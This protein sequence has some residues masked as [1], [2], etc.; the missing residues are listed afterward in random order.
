MK[1]PGFPG[2][3]N[4]IAIRPDRK[5]KSLI[6]QLTS[7]HPWLRQLLDWT[8]TSGSVLLCLLMLPTRLPGME[9][10]GIGPNWLLIWVVAWSVK[11]SVFEGALAGIVLGLLQDAM[12]SPNPTHAISLGIVGMLTSLIQKQ[13]FIQEDFISIALIVFGMAVVADTIFAVQLSILGGSCGEQCVRKVEDIW[14]Y[15][16]RVALASA[17]LS[18]LWAPVVYYPL[19]RWWQQM[20]LINNS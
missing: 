17:I 16:Q 5:S 6:P 10:L 14:T 13:R 9:L 3:K 4:K 11:R 20:K 1:I 12:T 2:S 15:Y 19:N 7:W 8:V 18:S